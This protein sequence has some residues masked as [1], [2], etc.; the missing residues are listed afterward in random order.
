MSIRHKSPSVQKVR[1]CCGKLWQ[2]LVQQG[3]SAISPIYFLSFLE[4][5]GT[6]RI[7]DWLQNPINQSAGSRKA[8]KSNFSDCC[9]LLLPFPLQINVV[10]WDSPLRIVNLLITDWQ[11][12]CFYHGVKLQVERA[13]LRELQAVLLQLRELGDIL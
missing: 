3:F 4:S 12:D 5:Q 6:R 10:N 11:R 7:Q 13:A 8:A 1:K 9:L 2:E